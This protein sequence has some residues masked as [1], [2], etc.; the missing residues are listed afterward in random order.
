MRHL[1]GLLFIVLISSCEK[2]EINKESNFP[3]DGKVN[4]NTT[5]SKLRS[6]ASST[7]TGSNLILSLKYGAGEESYDKTNILWT[8]VNNI[9][10]PEVNVSWKDATTPVAISAYAP[11]V[12]GANDLTAIPFSVSLNQSSDLL[13]SDLLGFIDPNFIPNSSLNSNQAVDINFT[14][15]LSKLNFNFTFGVNVGGDAAMSV[16][17]VIVTAKNKVTYNALT[18]VTTLVNESPVKITSLKNA[19]GDFCIIIPSQMFVSET[20]LLTITLNDGSI[21]N[22]KVPTSGH[23]FEPNT[24]YDINLIL[25]SN[26]VQLS[27][28]VVG[29]WE[30][31]TPIEGEI[32]KDRNINFKSTLNGELFSVTGKNSLTLKRTVTNLT[33]T[34]GNPAD[35]FDIEENVIIDNIIFNNITDMNGNG[36]KYIDQ[37]L[38]STQ[39]PNTL[40]LDVKMV[41]SMTKNGVS[42]KMEFMLKV[43]GSRPLNINR[44]AFRTDLDQTKFKVEEDELTLLYPPLV[45]IFWNNTN[46]WFEDISGVEIVSVKV[47]GLSQGV[48]IDDSGNVT[49]TTYPSLESLHGFA[50]IETI[51]DGV[52]LYEERKVALEGALVRLIDGATQIEPA[53][54]N[55]LVKDNRLHCKGI[56]ALGGSIELDLN[57]Y[58]EL[59]QNVT[60]LGFYGDRSNGSIGKLFNLDGSPLNRELFAVEKIDNKLKISLTYARSAYGDFYVK[61][62]KD[63]VESTRLVRIIFN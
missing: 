48:T 25:G 44:V 53:G 5:I 8:N 32:E 30:T 26:N 18:G 27:G 58:F 9:W 39:S 13:S 52:T 63:G 23:M 2:T 28:I 42:S 38:S 45:D 54:L 35:W 34:Y 29:N 41:V 59:G 43:G 3:K 10:T 14:H 16:E 4:I 37:V 60:I 11:S 24:S 22:Y 6:K 33:P 15:R 12:E 17:S 20:K 1:I 21:F 61:V 55:I 31:G 62:E 40:D 47:R 19:G 56:V 36:C 7:Y 51:K 50:D 49:G 46:H 57:N